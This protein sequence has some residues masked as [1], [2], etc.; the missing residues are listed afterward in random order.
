MK[1]VTEVVM[2]YFKVLSEHIPLT[3][4]NHAKLMAIGPSIKTMF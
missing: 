3:E 2:A 4:E 1:G